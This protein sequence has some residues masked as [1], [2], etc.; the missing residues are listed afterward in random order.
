MSGFTLTQSSENRF[1]S[2]LKSLLSSITSYN[3]TSPSTDLSD[4][5]VLVDFGGGRGKT[6]RDVRKQMPGLSG[7]VIVQDLP[8]VIEGQEIL[9]GVEAMA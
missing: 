4:D 1:Q 5:V 9:D 6:L 3:P 7:R 8:K 2:I